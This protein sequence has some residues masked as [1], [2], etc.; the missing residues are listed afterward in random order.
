[1]QTYLARR[2]YIGGSQEKRVQLREPGLT[3]DNIKKGRKR[4]KESKDKKNQLQF[5]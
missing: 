3:K 1:M 5:E 4:E 2:I